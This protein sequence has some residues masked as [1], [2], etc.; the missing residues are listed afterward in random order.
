MD[1]TSQNG[2]TKY[3]GITHMIATKFG[4]FCSGLTYDRLPSDV[5]NAIK[6]RILDTFAAALAGQ[7]LGAHRR[8][9]ALTRGPDDASIWGD[10]QRVSLRD[11]VMLNSFLAH[12][13]YMDDGDR[14]S[15][16]HPGAVVI[17][18][19]I[20]L[21]EVKRASGPAL[22][23][24]IAAG[25]EVLLRIG[26]AIYPSAVLRG[27]QSTAILGA[28]GSATACSSL[29][30]LSPQATKNAIGLSCNLGSGLKESL[31]CSSSQPLQ[32]ARACEGG[33]IA[34]LY[35][36][37]GAEAPDSM[38]ENGFVKAF[39]DRG[40][41]AAVL[42]ELGSRY[43]IHDTY[44]KIHGGC[45]GNHS[46]TDA[47]IELLRTRSI[48]PDDIERISISV[49]TVTMKG[50]IVEPQN[51]EQAQFCVAFAVAVAILEGN[52]SIF[53]FTN[54]KLNDPKIREMMH[55]VE[56]RLDSSLDDGCPDKR[57]AVA[58]VVTRNGRKERLAVENA[59]GE[60][61]FPLSAD[62]IAAKFESLAG[63]ILGSNCERARKAVMEIEAMRDVS[64]LISC[65]VP[66]QPARPDGKQRLALAS[67]S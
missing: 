26:Q 23:A 34:A 32:V 35:A 20:A 45:R 64:D 51:G 50:E 33:L 36:Q 38:V 4:E 60:P 11:A 21:A 19:A 14:F 48:S 43:R 15:G 30:N 40:D 61:E 52:A 27:F 22:V 18:S 58:E 57:G 17:P 54:E 5:T 53:Q 25:Y 2:G 7:Q 66:A 47:V 13:T 46:P 3:F 39:A 62:D 56:I 55:K 41:T 9:L 67:H 65:L 1:G 31:K 44:I 42:N 28:I 37:Q 8:L 12:C 29:L 24:A 59:R 16:A 6:Y 63:P 10:A 49:D